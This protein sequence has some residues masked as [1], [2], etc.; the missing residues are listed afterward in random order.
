MG[1]RIFLL[2]L[3][4]SF[5]QANLAQNR[6]TIEYS[7]NSTPSIVGSW[8][9][10]HY[11][12]KDQ[13][14]P[15]PNPSLYLTWTFFENGSERLYWDYGDNQIFCERWGRFELKPNYLVEEVLFLNPKNS[16]DCSRDPDMQIPR[17][18]TTKISFSED[19][20]HLHLQVGDEELIY[21]L[22]PKK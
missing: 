15:K 21:V 17:K 12:Y 6:N 16:S 1:L 7:E 13:I 14:F 5:T 22:A 3:A 2:L 9:Y 11:I 18:T 10:I 4:F 20:I 8:Q 19:H